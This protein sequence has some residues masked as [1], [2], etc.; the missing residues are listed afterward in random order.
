[1]SLLLIRDLVNVSYNDRNSEELLMKKD[2]EERHL[3]GAEKK[4]LERF[5]K[6]ISKMEQSGYTR[7]EL[8]IDIGKAN[9]F[10]IVLLVPLFLIGY[11]LDY[12][13]NHRIGFLGINWLIFFVAFVVLIVIHELIHGVCWSFFTPHHFKDIEFGI[14]KPS[15][16]PYCT[17]LE[18]LKKEAYIFGTVMP[19]VLLGI[20]PMI[21]GI[22]VNNS[23][24]LILG[25]IL[26]DSAAGDIMII[27]K[28]LRYKSD[29]GEV[30][31]MDHPTEAGG[32]VFER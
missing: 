28:L 3:S 5:E 6:I 29:S 14:M 8:T 2:K 1:M 10:A 31:Y 19:L 7:H 20:L 22:A 30:V 26:A 27:W 9:V 4:R 24:I 18:P 16:N 11:G 13:V 32:V 15:M 25:I 21:A 12:L 17:C 23:N